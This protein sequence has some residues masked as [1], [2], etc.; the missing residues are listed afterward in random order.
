MIQKFPF[1]LLLSVL[2]LTVQA[3]TTETPKKT[4][5]PDIPGT[6]L[7]D[8]GINRTTESIGNLKYGFWG[9]RTIN[10]YYLYDMRIGKSKFSFHPGI[11]LGMERFKL[12]SAGSLQNPTLAFDAEGN[13]RFASAAAVIYDADSLG[14]INWSSSYSTKKSMMILNYLDIPLEL[15]FSLKPEDPSRSFKIGI[16]GRVGYL[17]SSGTK[18]KYKENGELKKLKNNQDFNLSPIRYSASLRIYFGNFNLFGYYN[19]NP[20]FEKD[21]GPFATE[22]GTYTIGISLISF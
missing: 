10:V 18:I 13:T 19:L 16:G 4:G 14:Q 8:L 15:R 20:L 11:G 3:Q 6:F 22:A 21:K 1:I 17:L 12:N 5:R 7:V 2:S 9:S